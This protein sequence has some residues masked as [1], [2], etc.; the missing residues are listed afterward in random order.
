MIAKLF[1]KI[2]GA[3]T[4]L[5][6]RLPYDEK[7]WVSQI[8]AAL[9]LSYLF[10]ATIVFY[11]LSYLAQS[12]GSVSYALVGFVTFVIT[13]LIVLMDRAFILSDWYFQPNLHYRKK[14]DWFV[15]IVKRWMRILPRLA[16]SLFMAYV[17]SIFLI[18]RFY[19]DKIMEVI[20]MEN[21]QANSTYNNKLNEYEKEYKNKIALAKQKRN[22]YLHNINVLQTQVGVAMPHFDNVL[23]ALQKEYDILDKQIKNAKKALTRIQNNSSY[24]NYI[25]AKRAYGCVDAKI[26]LEENST[27]PT[28]RVICGESYTSSG[29][30]GRGTRYRNLQAIKQSY[31][32]E[33]HGLQD[34]FNA[35]STKIS[36][37]SEL[38]KEL[39]QKKTEIA[40]KISKRNDELSI[41]SQNAQKKKHKELEYLYQD[42]T[43]TLQKLIKEKK[44]AYEAYKKALK[45]K[46]LYTPLQDGP[47]VRYAALQTLYADERY[48]EQRKYFSAL[49]KIMMVL[50]ELM[51]ILMKVFFGKP[52]VY[53]VALQKRYTL[54]TSKIE[55]NAFE[56]F[57][58]KKQ[59]GTK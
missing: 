51:P 15:A 45:E 41:A 14:I 35:I 59:E 23:Q 27:I 47:M 12:G 8:G 18:L 16:L 1:I 46:G 33:M 26:S 11:S 48:G 28:T 32:L 3:D 34:E 52:S 31:V 5:L 10:I 44:H 58:D 24:K 7:V 4:K 39:K 30:E 50:M 17:L 56:L 42:A 38:L 37:T 36:E 25:E 22:D 49:L 54:V 53:A 57:D 40:A 43:T 55:D 29:T 9:L 20:Q 19:N 13:T 21:R 6:E 2:A